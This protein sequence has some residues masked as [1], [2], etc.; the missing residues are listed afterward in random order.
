MDIVILILTG[1]NSIK[2]NMISNIHCRLSLKYRIKEMTNI[3]ICIRGN[4]R[5]RNLWA[6]F[7]FFGN[8]IN[9]LRPIF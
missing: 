7:I 6:W 2:N 3:G 8:K 4:N 9:L 1:E 5:E